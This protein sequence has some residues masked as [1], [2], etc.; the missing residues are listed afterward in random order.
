MSLR[1]QL[2]ASLPGL[3]WT[4]S[5]LARCGDL[6]LRVRSLALRTLEPAKVRGDRGDGAVV[7]LS[8]E[9]RHAADEVLAGHLDRPRKALRDDRGQ[10]AAVD[11]ELLPMRPLQ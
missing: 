7:Q 1:Q 8:C 2:R 9:S 5:C 11:A 6:G 4:A 10:V 3:R